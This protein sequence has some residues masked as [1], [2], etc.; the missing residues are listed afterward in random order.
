MTKAMIHFDPLPDQN[1]A[2][3]VRRY[4][5]NGHEAISELKSYI[6]NN[7]ENGEIIGE[8]RKILVFCQV[9]GYLTFKFKVIYIH[10]YKA[11]KVINLEYTVGS[12]FP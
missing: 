12:L 11:I 7:Y 5:A 1:I 3:I 8:L 2:Q 6:E 9:F 4:R 10:N